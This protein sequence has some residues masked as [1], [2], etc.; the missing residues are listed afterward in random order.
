MF[1]K[2]FPNYFCFYFYF[3]YPFFERACKVV[4]RFFL[5]CCWLKCGDPRLDLFPWTH[6]KIAVCRFCKFLSKMCAA[7]S[8]LNKLSSKHARGMQQFSKQLSKTA[9]WKWRMQSIAIVSS[10]LYKGFIMNDSHQQ[11][12]EL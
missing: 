2:I 11:F 3:S 8:S 6:L 10:D 7:S 9:V 5:V 4:S 12:Y 1:S